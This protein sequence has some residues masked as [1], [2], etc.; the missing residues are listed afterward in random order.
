M[1]PGARAAGRR[2]GRGARAAGSLVLELESPL[3]TT[4]PRPLTFSLREQPERVRARGWQSSASRSRRR[5]RT[6]CASTD[7]SPARTRRP[8][9]RPAEMRRNAPRGDQPGEV[10]GRLLRMGTRDTRSQEKLAPEDVRHAAELAGVRVR[11][12]FS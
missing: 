4:P 5:E 8:R 11:R 3:L 9:T 10:T 12:E 1:G 7:S 6:R 2:A